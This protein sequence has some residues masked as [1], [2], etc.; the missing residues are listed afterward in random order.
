MNRIKFMFKEKD[1]QELPYKYLDD[2]TDE[3]LT[4][5]YGGGDNYS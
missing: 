3:R 5:T 2:N 1:L 4:A